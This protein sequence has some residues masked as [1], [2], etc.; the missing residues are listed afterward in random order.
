MKLIRDLSQLTSEFRGG[1]VTIGNFDG[2]HRG[3][4]RIVEQ[5]V[6][7]AEQLDG[8]AVVFTFDP[9]PVRLLRPAEVP[10]PLTWTR[11]KASLLSE[12]SVDAVFAYPTDEELLRLTPDEFFQQIIRGTLA[13]RAMV[14]GPNFHFGHD[15]VG[16][17]ELLGKLCAQHD[18]ALEVVPPLVV[19]G[20]PVSSSRIRRA[21]ADGH[22]ELA[23]QWL[24]HPYRLRG[25]VRHGASRGAKIGF[26][27]ANLDAIDTLVPASGVYAGRTHINGIPHAAAINVGPNPTFGEEVLKVEVHVLDFNGTIYGEPL[28]VDFL[29]R[30]RDVQTFESVDQLKK[31][32]HED[33]H[34]VRHIVK[35]LP[36]KLADPR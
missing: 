26:P 7:M 33:V 12:L 13:A 30:I 25:M 32:L 27:T 14:E 16:N 1:A 17:V 15:R 11:R 2:V 9:H 18:I 20:E 28:E 24:T 35:S 23:S 6:A 19:D 34:Q 36:S 22:I 21:I 4:A 31:Q 8:P 10:P 3:H 29:S 5:L